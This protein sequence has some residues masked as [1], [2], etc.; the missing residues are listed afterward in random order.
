LRSSLI[1]FRTPS[2]ITHRLD[3]L[4]KEIREKWQA[5]VMGKSKEEAGNGDVMIVAHG[6]ILRAFAQRWVN[7]PLEE[8]VALLMD[9]GGVGTLR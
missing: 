1:R 7:H 4:I 3:A 2:D 8:G 6:H 5:P 9:A